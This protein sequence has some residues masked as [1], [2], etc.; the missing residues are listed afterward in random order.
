LFSEQALFSYPLR[1]AGCKPQAGFP[2]DDGELGSQKSTI[3]NMLTMFIFPVSFYI[4]RFCL[5]SN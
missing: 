1:V 5:S 2:V 4:I 3:A